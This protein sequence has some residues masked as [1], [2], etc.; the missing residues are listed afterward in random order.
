MTIL[1]NPRQNPIVVKA[2]GDGYLYQMEYKDHQ[3]DLLY[4]LLRLHD[5]G[6]T[7]FVC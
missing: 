3:N 4:I 5:L 2:M 1:T 6:S 7:F